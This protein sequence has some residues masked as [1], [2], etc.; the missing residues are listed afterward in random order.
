V[1]YELAERG[2]AVL[3]IS[4]ELPEI[5]GVADRVLVMSEGRIAGELP[6]DQANEHAVLKLALRPE[7]A[8]VA[9]A[10]LAA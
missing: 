7:S 8:P 2:V 3:M 9:S 6:R 5:L 1:L 4:S 10:P